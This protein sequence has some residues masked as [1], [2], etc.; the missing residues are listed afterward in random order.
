MRINN[1]SKSLILLNCSGYDDTICVVYKFF[2]SEDYK[3]GKTNFIRGGQC[4]GDCGSIA[5]WISTSHLKASEI[6]DFPLR[7]GLI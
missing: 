5:L 2:R 4:R 6:F 1:A 7:D 3:K